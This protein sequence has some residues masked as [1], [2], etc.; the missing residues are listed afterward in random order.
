MSARPNDHIIK[1]LQSDILRMQGFRCVNSPALDANLG[2]MRTAFPNA[3][4]PLGAVHE[5]LCGRPEEAAA[6]AGF[7]AGMQ[8]AIM[9]R[10]SAAVWIS[11]VRTPYPPALRAFGL[12]PDNIIFVQLKREKEILWAMEESLKCS[13]LS[14]VVCELS[15]IDF[16][17]SRRLQLAVEQSQVTGFIIHNHCRKV[18]PTACVS[19]WSVSPLSSEPVSIDNL[20]AD[21]EALPGVGFPKWNVQLLRMRNGKPGS[22]ALHWKNGRFASASESRLMI[23]AERKKTG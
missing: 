17:A 23:E 2:P 7:I 6:T 8:A 5:F 1:S 18:Q 13:A 4:F 9:G 14:T 11:A 3:T 19:R 12:Q 16:T 15:H 20:N 10:D 21:T 22:W